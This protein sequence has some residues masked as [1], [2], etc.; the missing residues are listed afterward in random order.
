[1]RRYVYSF[2]RIPACEYL[3]GIQK[4]TDEYDKIREYVK[5]PEGKK[6]EPKDETE[7]QGE[8]KEELDRSSD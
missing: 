6:E 5:E 2:F 4:G 8:K 7:D 1:M 3:L